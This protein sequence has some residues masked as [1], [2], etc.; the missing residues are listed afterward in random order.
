MNK[1]RYRLIVSVDK[2]V[3]LNALFDTE[4]EAEKAR[5]KYMLINTTKVIQ[6]ERN[7]K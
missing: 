2:R 3:Y 1:Y 4:K 5:K 7:E 6:E